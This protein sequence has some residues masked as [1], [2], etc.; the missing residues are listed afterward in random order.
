MLTNLNTDGNQL[1]ITWQARQ[2][3]FLHQRQRCRISYET[4]ELRE[5]PPVGRGWAEGPR[6][7]HYRCTYI[8]YCTKTLTDAY[9]VSHKKI[10]PWGFLTFFPK[11]LGIF[12]PSFTHLSY[13][14]IYARAYIFIQLPTTLVVGKFDKLCHIKCDHQRICTFH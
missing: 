2:R 12:S 6:F 14:P 10:P 5:R 1:R 11:R 3:V 9:S 13:V 8:H 4:G 7:P